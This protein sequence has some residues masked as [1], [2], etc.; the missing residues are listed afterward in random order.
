MIF[1]VMDL[2]IC[3]MK[4]ALEVIINEVER[5]LD[6]KVKIVR[7]DRGGEYYGKYDE[8]GQCL[9]PFAKFIES[10]D[11]C[12]QYT[13]PGTPQKNHV[14]KRQNSTLMEM[15]KTP[16]RVYN[17]QK[18][19]LDSQ[20]IS[21]YFIGYP[22]KSKGYR[23]YCP[24]HSSR[25]I[26]TYNAKFLEN[27]E[28][29]GSVENQVVDIHEIRD[30]D[31]SPMNVHK[32]TTTLDVVPIFQNQE[33]HLNNKQ[34]PHEENNLPTQRIAFNKPARVR[35]LSIGDD[36]I[37]YLQETDFDAGIDNDLISFSQAIKVISL[38]CGLPL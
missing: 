17:P 12:A 9:G 35:K 31:S 18:K 16:A 38:K 2:S 5:Q 26:E 21:G 8:S 19:K 6:R 27:S 29:S 25:I 22:E 7:S 23:F 28:V 1:H 14:A 36:Y 13:M 33:Q 37:V 3:C 15:S 10:H 11:I 34:T 32:S 20:T 4:N 30:D 24:T